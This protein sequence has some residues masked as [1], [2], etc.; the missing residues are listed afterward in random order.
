MTKSF[1]RS[2]EWWSRCGQLVRGLWTPS[3]SPLV[4]LLQK[5]GERT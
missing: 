2:R 3:D 4:V 5:R 1:S